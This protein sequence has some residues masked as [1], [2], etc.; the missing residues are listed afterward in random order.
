MCRVLGTIFILNSKPYKHNCN[1]YCQ[2]NIV[3]FII[4][5]LSDTASVGFDHKHM[6]SQ[7]IVTRK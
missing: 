3:E 4:I 1:K 5:V 2:D 6:Q 7:K